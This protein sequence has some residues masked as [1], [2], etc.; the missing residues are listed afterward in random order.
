MDAHLGLLSA[1]LR[2]VRDAEHLTDPSHPGVSLDQAYHLAGFGPECARKATLSSRIY[3][4]A[5]GHGVGRASDVALD[6]ALA[7]DAHAHRYDLVDWRGRYPTL[8]AWT[9]QARYEGTGTYG[10]VAVEPLLEEAHQ[11]VGRIAFALWAD[12]RVREEFEWR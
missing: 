12:G 11:I 6:V 9:E 1:A 2:H 4:K 7:L 3:D 10:A 5:I 8:A